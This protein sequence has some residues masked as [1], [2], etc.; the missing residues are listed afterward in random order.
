MSSLRCQG[1]AC[2]PACNSNSTQPQ[3]HTQ[4]LPLLTPACLPPAICLRFSLTSACPMP[5]AGL[6]SDAAI[7]AEGMGLIRAGMPADEAA[8]LEAARSF[9]AL[10]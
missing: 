2:C 10:F 6:V 5:G 7:I 4:P 3:L 1:Q 8:Q 9:L